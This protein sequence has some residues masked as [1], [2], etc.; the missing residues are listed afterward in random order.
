MKIAIIG[1]GHVGRAIGAG[2]TRIGHEVRYGHREP[3]ERPKYAA[4]WG[5]LIVLA[6][7][8]HQ[9][10]N[11][12]EDIGS[13]MEDKI[14]IDATNRIGPNGEPVPCGDTSGAEELQKALPLAKVVKAFN[15]V[16]AQNQA[17]GHI[18]EKQLAGFVAGDDP[19]AKA[20]VMSLLKDLGYDPVDSGSLRASQH[21]EAMGLHLVGLGYGQRMGTA[22]GYQL[23]KG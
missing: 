6:V 21:L 10:S 5:E 2:V 7:P 19:E 20:A 11:L 3:G 1:K 9:I 4:E 12:V 16:F 14:V 17:T 22:I 8:Y 23:A 18:G 15:T 13:L